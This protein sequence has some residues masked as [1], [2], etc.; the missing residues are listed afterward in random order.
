MT[1]DN[2]QT[3]PLSKATIYLSVHTDE[4]TGVITT[5]DARTHPDYSLAP[6]ASYNANLAY[7][8][9]RKQ[10]TS[11]YPAKPA[12]VMGL[13]AFA[14]FVASGYNSK[15]GSS[16]P[17]HETI[18][19][20]AGISKAS[21]SRYTRLLVQSG[22]WAVIPGSGRTSTRYF[23]LFLEGGNKPYIKYLKEQAEKQGDA[24][25]FDLTDL[26]PAPKKAVVEDTA[27]DESEEIYSDD[28]PSVAEAEVASAPVEEAIEESLPPETFHATDHDYSYQDNY[29]P[30]DEYGNEP[31]PP[32]YD[33][34][35]AF[36]SSLP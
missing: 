15:T 32:D 27:G 6:A 1:T 24:F 18:L 26:D 25:P 13:K 12:Q 10:S 4:T 28:S 9:M 22:L 17:N 19:R 3:K 8:V 34:Q 36:S 11:Q 29:E 30:D 16:W 21:A 14:A 20:E 5:A 2:P 23:P 33:N 35:L 7:F 31:P